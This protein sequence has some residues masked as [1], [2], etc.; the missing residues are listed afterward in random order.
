MA[1]T[2]LAAAVP[3]ATALRWRDSVIDYLLGNGQWVRPPV[4]HPRYW[5]HPQLMARENPR[6]ATVLTA[7]TALWHTEGSTVGVPAVDLQTNL[8]YCDR[9]CIG[10]P[11][12]PH[13]DFRSRGGGSG[14]GGSGGGGSGSGSGAA[15]GSPAREHWLHPR[16]TGVYRPVIEGRWEEWD[17]FHAGPRAALDQALSGSWTKHG[18]FRPWQGFL[19]LAPWLQQ[20]GNLRLVPLLRAAMAYALLQPFTADAPPAADTGESSVSGMHGLRLNERDHAPLLRAL[21]TLPPLSAG[22]LVLWHPDI[23]I[24]ESLAAHLMDR[25]YVALYMSAMPATAGNLCYLDAQREAFSKGRTP[26]PMR[27]SNC[28]LS[29][30]ETDFVGRATEV[31]LTPAGRKA[32][33]LRQQ[34]KVMLLRELD[35]PSHSLVEPLLIHER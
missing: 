27:T 9:L 35:L 8:T 14:G 4:E 28:R 17:P 26:H 5:S 25:E 7:L 6:I 19:S 12:S 3:E 10:K 16:F 21:V 1:T 15:M 20:E 33:G 13:G 30:D 23:A 29:S 34:P 2:S 18:A 24:A 11:C 31:D 22:D 32:M